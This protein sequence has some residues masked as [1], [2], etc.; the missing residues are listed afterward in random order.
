[1]NDPNTGCGYAVQAYPGITA[2]SGWD[3]INVA[4]GYQNLGSGRVWATDFDWQDVDT[5][6]PAY[7]YTNG[8]IGY[9]M[10]HRR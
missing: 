7:D 1:V 4:V 2:V 10:T 8:L 6:G 9:M 3:A 5:V